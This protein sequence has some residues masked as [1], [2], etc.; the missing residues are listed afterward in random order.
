M[1]IDID[2][3]KF[4]LETLGDRVKTLGR[5]CSTA[6]SRAGRHR[7]AWGRHHGDPSI[8]PSPCTL[9]C[10]G[11]SYISPNWPPRASRDVEAM[12]QAD[13]TSNRAAAGLLGYA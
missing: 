7:V 8:C 3:C 6:G 9:N 11:R 12:Q 5:Q 2:I 13:K 4:M 10:T 1:K